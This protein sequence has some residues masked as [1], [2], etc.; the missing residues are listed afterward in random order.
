MMRI[1]VILLALALTSACEHKAKEFHHST[2]KFGIIIDMTLYDVD[3]ALAE[4]AF[5]TLD[6][7]FEYMHAAWS[8]WEPGSL[9]RMNVL[10]PTGAKFSVGPAVL[11]LIEQ[12]LI[13]SEKL[14][15]SVR[16]VS[17]FKS[18]RFKISN[19]EGTVKYTPN[20]PF[21][22]GF[23]VANQKLVIDVIFNI[24]GAEKKEE[25]TEKYNR[26]NEAISEGKFVP[27]FT[28]YYMQLTHIDYHLASIILP[29]NKALKM[30]IEEVLQY[31]AY[32]PFPGD[33][34]KIA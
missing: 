17:N 5:A 16:L 6:H 30:A 14:D 18:Q 8:P 20:N 26:A 10:I 19:N 3:E 29:I 1:F 2:L 34:D 7:D 22:I 25:Q 28:D 23:G 21:G 15:W 32:R 13:L 33:L 12:S 24:K 11:P 9:S 31:Y 4:T 27:V